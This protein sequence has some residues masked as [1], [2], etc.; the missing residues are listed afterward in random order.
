MAILEYK[1]DEEGNTTQ[2]VVGFQ[3]Y[4]NNENLNARI[5]LTIEDIKGVNNNWD[6]E[7][8]TKDRAEIV[9]RRKLQAWVRV[10][11]EEAETEE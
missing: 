5:N 11:K 10:E 8:I 1:F 9:A 4:A 7:N 3:T 2:I 6:F